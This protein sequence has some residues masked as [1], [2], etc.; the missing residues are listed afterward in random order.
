MAKKATKKATKK[1][2]RRSTAPEPV[3][4]QSEAVD[5]SKS[6]LTHEQIAERAE[7]IWQEKGCPPDQDEAHWLEAEAQ[8]RQEAR[9]A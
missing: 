2:A 8:L 7:M 3:Q 5:D 4:R 9:G 1:A 6:A